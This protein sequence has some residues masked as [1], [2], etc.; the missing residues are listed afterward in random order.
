MPERLRFN[1]PGR[2]EEVIVKNDTNI[3]RLHAEPKSPRTYEEHHTQLIE[4]DVLMRQEERK[5]SRLLAELAQTRWFH[6]S[7][8]KGT[9][10][11]SDPARYHG[12]DHTKE[13]LRPSDVEATRLTG[14]EILEGSDLTMDRALLQH[15]KLS[16]LPPGESLYRTRT[17]HS[18]SSRCSLPQQNKNSVHF[19]F[20]RVEV[21]GDLHDDFHGNK[22]L[23]QKF[24]ESEL[25]KSVPQDRKNDQSRFPSRPSR[26][27]GER[28]GIV[29][30]LEQT[31]V[32]KHR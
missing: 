17:R 2:I 10:K 4:Y 19:S 7:I 14:E 31:K 28:C 32:Q 8:I 18:L 22:S 16:L 21:E 23:R 26:W 13:N 29:F 6:P 30:N 24:L 3:F 11:Q 25:N 20:I 1:K 5:Y 15:Q 27:N 9:A 12:A